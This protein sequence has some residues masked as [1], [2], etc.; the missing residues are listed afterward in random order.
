MKR[1][2]VAGWHNRK[3]VGLSILALIVLGLVVWQLPDIVD[4]FIATRDWL[5]RNLAYSIIAPL[6]W[7]VGAG[8][9]NLEATLPCPAALLEPMGGR[10]SW[11]PLL[12]QE[13][14]PT[15]HPPGEYSAN[16]AWGD[17]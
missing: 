4:G 2:M 1:W 13:R 7:V 9:G 8:P 5:V 15:S 14:W 16:T 17:R 6:A 11:H 3:W 10:A 12:F